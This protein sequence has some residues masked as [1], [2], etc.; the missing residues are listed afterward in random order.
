MHLY[1]ANP[2]C[3][4]A[5]SFPGRISSLVRVLVAVIALPGMQLATAQTPQTPAANPHKPATTKPLHAHRTVKSKAR[6]QATAPVAAVAPTPTPVPPKPD[7]PV[8]N[9]PVPPAVTWDSQGLQ[10]KAINSSLRQILSDVSSETGAKVEGM[11]KDERI[12]GDYGPAP[13]RDVLSQLLHGSGYN[14]L[15]IGDQG[16]GTPREIVL[17][18]QNASPAPQAQA[19]AQPATPADDDQENNDEQQPAP[20]PVINRPPLSLPGQGPPPNPQQ[21]WQQMQLQQQLQ[22]QQIQQQNPPP[23]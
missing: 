7:W 6:P 10:I 23:Q 17:S 15:M 21:R 13:A 16:E 20:S 8:N 18:A 9:P 19:Q 22:Q 14:V 2:D 4:R 1:R 12:F 5:G 3:K 11:G